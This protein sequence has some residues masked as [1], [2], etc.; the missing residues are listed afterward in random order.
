M[1]P[2]ESAGETA[3]LERL[4][5]ED[6]EGGL[7]L[8]GAVGWNQTADDW[9][10]FIGHGHTVGCRDGTGR[11][12]ATASALPQGDRC[13]WLS[14]VLVDVDHRHR[15]LATT[16]VDDGVAWLAQRGRVAVLDAT[17]E[18]EPVYRRSGFVGGF[19]FTRWQGEGGGL[20]ATPEAPATVGAVTDARDHADI[21]ALDA[22]ATGLDRGELLRDFLSRPTTRAWLAADR[23]GFVISRAGRRAGQIGPLAAA[24]ETDALALLDAALAAHGGAVFIDVPDHCGGVVA[25]LAQRGFTR[26]RPFTRMASAAGPVLAAPARSYALAGPEFG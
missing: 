3:A 1:A 7:A 8:S 10:F 11:L 6:V 26:Q 25:A 4:T 2:S 14:M 17:P 5:L 16:L 22:A 15:G 18:G 13:G 20:S 21:L 12:V 24:D 9:A 19:G 23:S